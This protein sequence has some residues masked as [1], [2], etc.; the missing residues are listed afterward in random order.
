M[1]PD[2]S[3]I[4]AVASA[5]PDESFKKDKFKR[6]LSEYKETGI[7]CDRPKVLTPS[8]A[9]YYESVRKNKIKAY[10]VG[11]KTNLKKIFKINGGN[12]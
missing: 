10:M 9:A 12:S 11:N 3:I 5:S 2:A 1:S 4:E 7:H 8:R 6:Y